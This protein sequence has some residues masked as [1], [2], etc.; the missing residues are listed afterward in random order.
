[1]RRVFVKD[2]M[3]VSKIGM[4]MKSKRSRRAG[5]LMSHAVRASLRNAAVLPRRLMV[6]GAA[7]SVP[8][9]VAHSCTYTGSVLV[10]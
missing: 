2:R 4:P 1:M 7:I 8:F 9:P 10:M 3:K 5:E 6:L